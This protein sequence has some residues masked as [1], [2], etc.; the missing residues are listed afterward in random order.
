[1]ATDRQQNGGQIVAIQP[2][3]I[4]KSITYTMSPCSWHV[5]H[6]ACFIW[7]TNTETRDPG[8]AMGAPSIPEKSLRGKENDD[9]EQGTVS[10]FTREDVA[11][12]NG[13]Q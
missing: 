7:I 10:V 6:L 4:F 9:G 13:H 2:I 8:G 1:M 5:W 3:T 12:C 11:G